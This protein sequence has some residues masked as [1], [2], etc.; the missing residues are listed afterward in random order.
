[1]GVLAVRPREVSTLLAAAQLLLLETFANQCALA[2]ER[3]ALIE[4]RQAARVE[5]ESERLRSAL[6]SS[7]SHDL[8]TPLATIAGAASALQHAGSLEEA[9][10]AELTDSIVH[11]SQ[12][13]NDLIANLMFATRLEAGGV[14]LRREWTTV[15]EVVGAGL[16]KLRAAL[17]TH[18]TRVLIPHDLPLIRVDNAMLPQVV[19]NLVD[20]ALRY[21]PAGTPIEIAA[22]TNDTQ[23]VVKVADEGPGIAADETTKVFQRF[24]RGRGARAAGR[25]RG[26]GLG[27]TICE[28][29]VKAHGGRI[30]AEVNK[31]RGVVFYFSLP[32]ERPQPIVPQEAA[33]VAP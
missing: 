18:P 15:E 10:R 27:L 1:V 29:I 16:A 25:E 33:E 12:R 24:Y 19:F 30:W 26:I 23:V 21:T 31:P 20:N 5:A 11:E 17:A 14:E 7:V 8:R 32:I 28:G 4:G 2:L 9:T 22:W 13:L 3:V 6:L